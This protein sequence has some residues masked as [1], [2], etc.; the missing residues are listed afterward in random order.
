MKI[1][2]SGASGLI[3]QEIASLLSAQGHKILQLHRNTT[4][5]YPY[6][7]IEKKIINLGKEVEIDIV[8]NL[9]GEN[10]VQGRWTSEKK[11]RILK[12]RVDGTKLISEYFSKL[13]Y[14]PKVLISGSAIGYYGNRNAQSIDETSAK[15]TGFLS[16][17]CN[18][19]EMATKIATNSGIRVANIRLGIV[20]SSTAG[21][22]TKMLTPF[23]AGLGGVIGNGKQ[24]MSW[25]TVNDVAQII[26]H[27]INTEKLQGPVN[28]VSPNPVT[29]YQFT[30]ILA[31][32]LHRPSLFLLPAFLAK[33]IFGEMANELLLTSTKVQ[34]Q[35]LLQSGYSF[36][37]PTLKIALKKLLTL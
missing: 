29:N 12:S 33:I 30:K 14:K 10:I 32:I 2:I 25:I 37:D 5:K 31:Q 6:W 11:K 15:G 16:D 13:P 1:L 21:A 28:I 22:L 23:K 3:G 36:K 24:Y 26:T 35:K 17:V 9:A 27:I 7:N 4:S 19:W 20:L 34:P 18:E 8:I